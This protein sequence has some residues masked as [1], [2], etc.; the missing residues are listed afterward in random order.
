MTLASL[1][2]SLHPSLSRHEIAFKLTG[3][4]GLAAATLS[5]ATTMFLPSLLPSLH[6]SPT[7]HE[8][9]VKIC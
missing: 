2:P 7:R 9:V 3:S 4:E 8:I 5:G 1:L 6:P